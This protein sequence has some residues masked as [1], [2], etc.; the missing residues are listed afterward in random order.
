MSR[1]WNH[2]DVTVG[3]LG[4]R[5]VVAPGDNEAGVAVV[6][7]TLPPKTLGAPL[8]RHS[9]EDEISVVLEGVLG[10]E[11]GGEVSTAGPGEVVVK[12][13]NVWHTFWNAGDD[14][15]HFFE[16]IAPG[17]FAAYFE[18]VAGVFDERP[19][20]DETMRR[21]GEIAGTYDLEMD[22]ESVPKLLERHDLGL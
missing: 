8:H 9:H 1:T 11:Q 2:Y 3:S 12:A 6:E 14:T 17:G 21:I 16:F 15:L 7:H 10:A 22:P 18:E 13:R 19:V 4:A 20:D 5:L